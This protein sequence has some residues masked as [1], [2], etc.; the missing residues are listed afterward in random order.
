MKKEI[1]RMEFITKNFNGVKAL[2]NVYLNVFEGEVLALIGKSGAGKTVLM[3]ILSGIYT[4][5]KGCIYYYNKKV[6]ISNPRDSQKLGIFCI[7]QDLKLVGNFSIAQNIF[8]LHK[9]V[10][11]NKKSINQKASVL[12]K[13]LGLELDPGEKASS[14]TSGQQQLVEIAQALSV[15]VKLIVMDGV[16]TALTESETSILYE[17]IC[18]LRKQGVSIIF[19][20]HDIEYVMKVAD[21]ITILRDGNTVGTI[22]KKEFQKD[23]LIKLM[24]GR[25][26]KDLYPKSTANIGDV[27]FK[28]EGVSTKGI[29]RDISFSVKKGE[30][31][32]ITGLMGC[33]R[34][35]LLGVIYGLVP[36]V[37]G[38]MYLNGKDISIR[39]PADAIKH[40]IGFIPQNRDDQGL[41]PDMTALGNMVL[42]IVD[43]VSNFNYINKE[44][45]KIISKEYI[46]KFNIKLL[47]D[48]QEVKYLSASDKQKIVLS[49]CMSYDPQILLLAEPTNGMDAYS[50]REI[51]AIIDLLSQKGISI[52]LASS[53]LYEI[54]GM[55]DRVIVLH[56]GRIKGELLREEAIPEKVINLQVN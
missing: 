30:I 23:K 35:E 7:H 26:L 9:K 47:D 52:I 22:Q 34:T 20:T 14:L 53:D 32:G 39:N 37:T 49:R 28:M 25:E 16:T 41:I 40:K 21:R 17:V 13:S 54:I 51:Q 4:K 42:S 33:G 50:R 36:K 5:D 2:K 3:K 43:K 56:E 10:I 45:L 31:L 44:V 55:C 8:M 12:L 15:N 1:L 19:I 48:S 38:N 46:K 18:K 29:L 11:L 27:I 6:E 24:V